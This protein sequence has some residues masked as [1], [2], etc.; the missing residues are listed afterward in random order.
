MTE[1]DRERWDERYREGF[2]ASSAPS[3]LLTAY[4]DDLPRGR[5]LDVATGT[6]RN[7]RFLAGRGY[8]VDAVD[9]SRVALTEA[10]AR[11]AEQG[12]SVDWVQADLDDFE[13]PRGV[14]DVVSVSFYYLPERLPDLAAALADG[15]VLAYEHA[16]KSAEPVDRGPS[17]RYR[18]DSNELLDAARDHGLTVLYYEEV[19]EETEGGRAATAR[20]L[21]RNSTGGAQRY[22]HRRGDPATPDAR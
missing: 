5:A 2:G 15:G 1:R 13:F 4:V 11:A 6:G 7:A 10:R 21:A 18:Y 14:Y 20:L 8:E 3:G 22:P 12:V 19:T 17:A 16:V 9:I